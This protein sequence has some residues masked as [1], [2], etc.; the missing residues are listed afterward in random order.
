MDIVNDFVHL[1]KFALTGKHEDLVLLLRRSLPAISRQRPDLAPEV[2][3]LLA[4]AGSNPGRAKSAVPDP[5]PVDIDSRLELVRR[6]EFPTINIEPTWDE[7]VRDSLEQVILER[8]QEDRLQAAG[9]VPTRS[10]LFVGPPGVGKSLAARHVAERL[11]RP[12]MTLDLAAVMSSF[13]GRTGN[14][15]RAVLDFARRTPSVLLLDEF[16]AIAKRRDDSAEVGELKRLVTVLLQ[17]IDDWPYHSLLIAATNHPDLLDPAVWRRFDKVINFPLPSIENIKK[18]LVV[19][20][21]NQ[22]QVIPDSLL[23]I[24]SVLLIG[25]SFADLS[26]LI[27][28]ARRESVIKNVP[29]SSVL[30]ELMRLSLRE[31]NHANRINFAVSLAQNGFSQRE[32]SEITGVSRDTIRNHIK[33]VK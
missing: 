19:A 32:A 5:V 22:D 31:Q 11:Q 29:L 6:E 15:I 14:N 26:K 21:S 9:V 23:Q 1:A 33:L 3:K 13:L 17:A 20:L 30:D 10:L 2:T 28:G 7:K 24:L 16:D 18:A 8:S 12:L 4:Q 27:L 25:K